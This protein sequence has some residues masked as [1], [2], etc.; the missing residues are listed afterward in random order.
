MHNSYMRNPYNPH[1]VFVP[2]SENRCCLL[3]L[4]IYL[5]KLEIPD[6]KSNGLRHPVLEALENMGRDLRRC[7]FSS[8]FGLFRLFGPIYFVEGRSPTTSN[9]K[10]LCL[11]TR[12]LCGW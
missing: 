11:C 10:V 6:R 4:T 1:T 7:N 3:L 12:C 8:F 5:G 2:V 9:F